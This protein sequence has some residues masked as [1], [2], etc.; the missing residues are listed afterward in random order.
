MSDR[1]IFEIQREGCS[2]LVWVGALGSRIVY[3]SETL[4]MLQEDILLEDERRF[5][6]AKEQTGVAAITKFGEFVSVYEYLQRLYK[7]YRSGVGKHLGV[8]V[9]ENIDQREHK[10]WW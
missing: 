6:D 1:L 9:Y 2:I 3:P 8:E 7:V 10:D 5:R 4:A